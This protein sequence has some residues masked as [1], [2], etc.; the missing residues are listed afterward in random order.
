MIPDV[1]EHRLAE[2]CAPTLLG[3][4]A[5][6]LLSLSREE[7]PELP[8]ALR[9]YNR[10]LY[11]TGLRFLILRETSQRSLIL[12]FRPALLRSRLNTAGAKALLQ[13][14]AASAN[15][16]ATGKFTTTWMEHGSVSP[17]MTPAGSA[18][19]ECWRQETRFHSCCKRPEKPCS[20]VRYHL[21]P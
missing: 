16:A 20:G 13:R 1:L 4:K 17:A 8:E 10:T 15:S 6:S 5:A 12:V 11:R 3:A 9:R 19:A 7:F 18:C 21:I 14:F 2:H